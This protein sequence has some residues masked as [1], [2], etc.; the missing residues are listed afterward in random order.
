MIEDRTSTTEK[1]QINYVDYRRVQEVY[2]QGRVKGEGKFIIN[3]I[4]I[5]CWV[6]SRDQKEITKMFPMSIGCHSHNQSHYQIYID[7]KL[8]LQYHMDMA[9]HQQRKL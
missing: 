4:L 6:C 7:K 9:A 5:Y 8:L 3:I 2:K 1:E